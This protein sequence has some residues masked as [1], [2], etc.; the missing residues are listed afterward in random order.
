MN[1]I[2]KI[3][4]LKYVA[5]FLIPAIFV[6]FMSQ[7]LDNDSWFV[8]AEG[9]HLVENGIHYTDV[10]TMHE[11]MNIVVQN[12]GFAAIFYLVY[13]A[14]GAPGLYVMMLGLNFVICYLV[15]KICMLLSN[16]NVNLSLLIMV[17]MDILLALGFVTTRAQMVS[18]VIMLALIYVLELYIK[19]DKTKYLWWV[20]VLSILQINMHASVWWMLILIMI[21]YVI[22]AI[23]KPKLHLQGYRMK[24][25]I[26]AGVV[27]MLVGLINP[28]GIKMVTYIFT[29]Y[30]VS[31]I[32]RLVNEMASFDLR[33]IFNIVLYAAMVVVLVL[34][35]FG[36]RRRVRVR[37]LLMFFGFLA[38]GLNSVK[39]MS[40]FVLVMF[41][42]LAVVYKDVRLGLEKV[43]ND[44][45][46]RRAVVFWVGVVAIG[47]FVTQCV[48]L[49]P[50]IKDGPDDK[51][52]G[53]VDAIEESSNGDKNMKIYVGYDNGGYVEFRGYKAY[54][55]PRAEVFVK[56]NNGKED[57]LK[58]WE[59]MVLEKT[60]VKEFLDKYD[61]DYLI[62]VERSEKGLYGMEDEEYE[63]IYK[64][65]DNEDK[66]KV[67]K[68]VRE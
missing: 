4:S 12:Y 2:L 29:S 53:A 20:P 13:S 16:K 65:E 68:H 31:E 67:L 38:L 61:F 64:N 44:E 1:R 28:Y 14:L 25:L 50:Q 49:I 59:S 66:V 27:A 63:E 57:Y 32:F 3:S 34:L 46:A 47:V 35:I 6:M 51:L 55:D 21:A 19:T 26:I 5:A 33:S 9:R 56:K 48:A 10:L 8:L 43:L 62:T 52:I 18:Y 40:Q 7:E 23:R 15:Y 39:G 37:Y 41:L 36:K 11:G 60:D 54:L 42:P 30:G 45:V 22:D 24:P 58:E 17:A